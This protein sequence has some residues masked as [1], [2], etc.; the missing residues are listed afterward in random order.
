MSNLRTIQ[1]IRESIKKELAGLYPEREIEAII[2]VL[3]LY[4]LDLKR[5]EI[6]LR[7]H[8]ILMPPDREWFIQ[9]ISKLKEQIPVQHITRET[10]FYD[11]RLSVSPAALI[12]RPETEELVKWIIDDESGYGTRIWD[13]GT[14]TGCIAL[15]LAANLSSPKIFASDLE[16]GAL[17][18]ARENARIL[19][20]E[21]EFLKHD[22]L[23]EAPPPSVSNLDIIVSNPP[24]I[25]MREKEALDSNVRDHDPEEA[26][27][28]PD[29][30]PL[31]YYRHI[32]KCDIRNFEKGRKLYLEIH[33]NFAE[34]I[35]QLL[36]EQGYTDIIIKKDIH[37]KDRM[38]RAQKS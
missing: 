10:F 2:G 32:A 18:L 25:P 15:A 9:A 22:I 28:V 4:R 35:R 3:C 26:L 29:E 6:G 23:N 21:V 5:H 8:E 16:D 12:P 11:L 38:V 7:K 17:A 30:D 1:S 20:L 36:E 34:S 31:L 33:E 37:G 24:Y 14:G 13:I 19:K 27:F